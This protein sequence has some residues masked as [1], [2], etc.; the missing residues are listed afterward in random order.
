MYTVFVVAP[1]LSEKFYWQFVLYYCFHC[2]G[3]IVK[4]W[5]FCMCWFC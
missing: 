4:L 1:D 3:L 2:S 5:Q